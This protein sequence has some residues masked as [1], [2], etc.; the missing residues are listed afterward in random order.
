MNIPASPPYCPQEAAIQER[1]MIE[2]G[3]SLPRWSESAAVQ[4]GR[5]EGLAIAA[6]ALSLVSFVNLLGAEKAL[7]S[8]VL[9]ALA[10]GGAQTSVARRRGLLA[11]GLSLLYVC[12]IVVVL[13]VFR[14]KLGQLVQ[15]LHELS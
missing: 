15:L 2:N 4:R 1:K 7:L 13:I 12:T 6:L 9:G 14:E 10:F 8:V 5:T 11:I 3:K